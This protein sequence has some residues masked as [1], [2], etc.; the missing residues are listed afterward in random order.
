MIILDTLIPLEWSGS[1]MI[2]AFMFGGS[3]E[4]SFLTFYVNSY[5]VEIILYVLDWN[6]VEGVSIQTAKL[7]SVSLHSYWQFILMPFISASHAS[8]LTVQNCKGPT[9]NV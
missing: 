8:S 2:Y 3:S 4:A 1:C 6:F 9:H 5:D 7:I